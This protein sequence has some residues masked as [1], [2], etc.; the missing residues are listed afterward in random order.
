MLG[1]G[2]AAIIPAVYSSGSGIKRWQFWV[3]HLGFLGGVGVVA[4]AA[5]LILDLQRIE[6]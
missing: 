3:L 4:V 5:F 6:P 2:I 1:V